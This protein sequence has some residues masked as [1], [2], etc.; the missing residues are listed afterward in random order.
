MEL[1]LG[2]IETMKWVVDPH[3]PTEEGLRKMRLETPA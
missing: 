2:L 3:E 1:K